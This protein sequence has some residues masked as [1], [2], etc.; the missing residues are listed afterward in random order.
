MTR[1]VV[2]TVQCKSIEPANTNI[3]NAT[4]TPGSARSN[5]AERT[6][7]HNAKACRQM[8]ASNNADSAT[9]SMKNKTK[10]LHQLAHLHARVLVG[11]F[12]LGIPGTTKSIQIS[13][14]N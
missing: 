11:A 12:R 2:F 6:T 4:H 3:R 10:Q 9:L 13:I 8:E 1:I 14:F 5:I 7:P